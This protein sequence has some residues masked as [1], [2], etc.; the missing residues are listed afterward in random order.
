MKTGLL[1]T[2]IILL[3]SC[4]TGESIYELTAETD[5]TVYLI[6]ET[7]VVSFINQG[8]DPLFLSYCG[9]SVPAYAIEKFS[10]DQWSQVSWQVC[11]AFP[12]PPRQVN[13]GQVVSETLFITLSGAPTSPISGSYR[14]RF[15]W[16]Q[17]PELYTRWGHTV[18]NSFVLTEK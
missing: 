10:N 9:E 11:P 16:R 5:K 18:S 2:G 12:F 7:A 6:D 8:T 15:V 14:F 3:A 17:G 4:D 13:P 1:L